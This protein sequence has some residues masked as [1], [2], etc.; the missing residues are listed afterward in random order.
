MRESFVEVQ[1]M[2]AFMVLQCDARQWRI[3]MVQAR[4]VMGGHQ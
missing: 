3:R 4:G 1:G 2:R